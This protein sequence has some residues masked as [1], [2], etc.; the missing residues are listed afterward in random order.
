MIPSFEDLPAE[1]TVHLLEPEGV[2]DVHGIGETAL[3]PVRPAIGNA[4]SRA[5]GSHFFELPITPDK[6]LRAL[7]KQRNNYVRTAKPEP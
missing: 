7:E 1:L 6:V 4:I 5:V 2:T 3:P